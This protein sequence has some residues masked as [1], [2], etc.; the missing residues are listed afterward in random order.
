MKTKCIF[1]IIVLLFLQSATLWA[2]SYWNLSL[3]T[4]QQE[5]GTYDANARE[6]YKKDVLIGYFMAIVPGFFVHGAGNFYAGNA[7]RGTAILFIG[8]LSTVAF[9]YGGIAGAGGEGEMT[10]FGKIWMATSITLFFGTWLWDIMTVQ[11]SIQDR[12]QPVNLS[13]GPVQS[14]DYSHNDPVFGLNLSISF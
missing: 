4:D 5:G 14:I 3:D 7:K 12:H 9:V 13:I 6:E 11:D 8:T 1:T 2:D 10:T